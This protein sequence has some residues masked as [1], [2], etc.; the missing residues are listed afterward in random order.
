VFHGNSN[1]MMMD[2]PSF[3]RVKI[4][5]FK[6]SK[7]SS[8]HSSHFTIVG[9][10][11]VGSQLVLTLQYTGH[12][13]NN[14]KAAVPWTLIVNDPDRFFDALYLP[15]GVNLVEISKM[16]SDALQACH[17]H[18]Y[19]RQQKGYQAFI[20]KHLHP[21]DLCI[22]GKKRKH[23]SDHQEECTTPDHQEEG[24]GHHTTI[25][26]L[27]LPATPEHHIKNAPNTATTSRMSHSP[28]Q[29]PK[30]VKGDSRAPSLLHSPSPPPDASGKA[31]A[32]PIE[33]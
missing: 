31:K 15:S 12:A 9:R 16:K 13:S 32:K 20:F 17:S 29:P 25:P 1:Q 7:E 6:I 8:S 3:L 10:L 30:D 22:S 26:Q 14:N 4:L 28:S 23:D 18:W 33:M 27:S 19:K 21:S 11:L 2:C 5:V 24:S